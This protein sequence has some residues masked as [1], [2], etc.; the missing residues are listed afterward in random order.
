MAAAAGL[1]GSIAV[2][3]R[4]ALA[5]D[6]L[7]HIA[8]PGIAIAL[9]VHVNPFLGGLIALVLG[10][11]LVWAIEYRSRIPTDVVVGVIFSAALAMGSLLASGDELIEAL[12][13]APNTSDSF[14]LIGLGA[15]SLVIVFI[16][17]YRSQLVIRLVSPDLA[18]PAGINVPRLDLLYLLAFALT[19]ALG[20]RYL[21][22]LLMGS[23][24]IIPAATAMR[25]GT[26][27]RTMQTI[28]VAIAMLATL[29]GMLLAPVLCLAA[30]PLV[31]VIAA[32]IFFLSLAVRRA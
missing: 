23:L 21:G 28:S 27:L 11:V 13:G 29:S 31:I 6:A 14:N 8:L 1:M 17:R 2:M 18:R 4:M 16:V 32:S 25:L 5:S 24:I 26:N 20:L 15:A 12:F 30:G 9:L 7:S 3:R 22:V 19:I 10:T